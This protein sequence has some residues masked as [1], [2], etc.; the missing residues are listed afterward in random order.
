MYEALLCRSFYIHV[1]LLLTYV[2]PEQSIAPKHSVSRTV[3]LL[4]VCFTHQFVN[5]VLLSA[6]PFWVIYISESATRNYFSESD[7]LTHTP[8]DAVTEA[9]NC[10]KTHTMCNKC[11]LGKEIQLTARVLCVS[12]MDIT[13]STRP[14]ACTALVLLHLLLPILLLLLLS[15]RPRW[16]VARDARG[17]VADRALTFLLALLPTSSRLAPGY[18]VTGAICKPPSSYCCFSVCGWQDHSDNQK[19][20][21]QS[22]VRGIKTGLAAQLSDPK[23]SGSELAS[24]A[25]LLLALCIVFQEFATLRKLSLQLLLILTEENSSSFVLQDCADLYTI[26]RS[27]TKLEVFPHRVPSHCTSTFQQHVMIFFVLLT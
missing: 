11:I 9:R 7:S 24:D 1:H 2:T 25:C 20:S 19:Q 17:P 6:S 5:C 18:P 22:Q 8:S 13:V 10:I 21:C 14:A 27:G 23:D 15:A 4:T 3:A 26:L 16:K 12:F